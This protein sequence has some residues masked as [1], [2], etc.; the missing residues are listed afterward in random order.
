MRAAAQQGR[1]AQDREE[2]KE[3]RNRVNSLQNRA[4]LLN[5]PLKLGADQFHES[6]RRKKKLPRCIFRTQS[7]SEARGKRSVPGNTALEPTREQ[8]AS[9]LGPED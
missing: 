5:F 1:K 9:V 4:L 3:T 7:K 8:E 6:W 2:G